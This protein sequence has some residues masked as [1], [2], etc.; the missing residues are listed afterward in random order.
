MG[1]AN[2]WLS[3]WD[4]LIM[5]NHLAIGA[6]GSVYAKNLRLLYRCMASLGFCQPRHNFV[7]PAG[8]I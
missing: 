4:W 3:G 1:E 5:K 8:V 2:R 6:I 7:R